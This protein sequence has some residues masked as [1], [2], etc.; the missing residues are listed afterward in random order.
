MVYF[1]G[2]CIVLIEF[3]TLRSML[4]WDLIVIITEYPKVAFSLI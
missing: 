4:I 3:C 1:V 2:C